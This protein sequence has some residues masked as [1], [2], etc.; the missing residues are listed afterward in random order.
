MPGADHLPAG[1]SAGPC[2]AEGHSTTPSPQPSFSSSEIPPAPRYK[3]AL[4]PHIPENHKSSR[5]AEPLPPPREPLHHLTAP[6]PHIALRWW[7]FLSF[8]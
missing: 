4:T 1:G 5:E 3:L 2:S 7:G 6:H 8:S